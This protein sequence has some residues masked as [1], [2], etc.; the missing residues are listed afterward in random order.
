LKLVLVIL[1]VGYHHYCLRI[2]KAFANNQV[3][4][5]ERFFRIFNEVPVLL[6][7]PIVILVVFK[8]F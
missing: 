1:L 8:P 7:V 5:S 4:H 6:L 2:I 3:P